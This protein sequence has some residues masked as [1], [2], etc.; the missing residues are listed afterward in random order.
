M[1]YLLTRS[2]NVILYGSL[3]FTMSKISS[4]IKIKLSLVIVVPG[5][6]PDGIRFCSIDIFASGLITYQVSRERFHLDFTNTEHF[7]FLGLLTTQTKYNMFI[8]IEFL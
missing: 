3:G 5:G 8:C 1:K 6:T 4:C 2:C 7:G